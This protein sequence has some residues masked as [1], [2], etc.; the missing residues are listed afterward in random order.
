MATAGVST[1]ASGSFSMS[2]SVRASSSVNEP[3]CRRR[4]S[5]SARRLRVRAPMSAAS[6]RTYVPLLHSTSTV[7]AGYG[8][9][10]NAST[11]IRSTCG[12]GGARARPPR[13]AGRARGAAGRRPSRPTPS[14]AAARSHRGTP[15]R[16]PRLSPGRSASGAG[17]R[18]RP[19]RRGSWSTRR[20]RWS[21]RYPLPVSWR[22]RSSRV[23]RPSP[24][25]R[26]PVASGSSVPAWPTRRWR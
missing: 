6:D 9:G 15:A 4:S 25:R 10:S 12:R 8:P 14:A 24:T 11:S 17:R 23:A 26:T 20:T 19:T 1:A 21:P 18:P 13:L 5:P 22:K 3:I 7:A 16:P 2:A